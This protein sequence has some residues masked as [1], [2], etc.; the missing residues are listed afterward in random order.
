[1]SLGYREDLKNGSRI[2][3]MVEFDKKDLLDKTERQI[4][5]LLCEK[6]VEEIWSKHKEDLIN[7]FDKEKL[8]NI[9]TEAIQDKIKN[10][11]F[12]ED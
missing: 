10:N 12:R 1:M 8:V 6:M 9:V 7:S 11:L 2:Q 3:A 4:F 5:N